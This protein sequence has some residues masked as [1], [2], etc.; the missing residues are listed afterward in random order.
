MFERYT[1]KARRVIFFARYEASEYGSTL[2]EGEHL[3]LGILREAGEL[4]SSLSPLC[5][6]TS[7]RDWL[8]QRVLTREKVP[9]S[10]D[11]PFS[12]EAKRA[13]HAAAKEAD[14]LGHRE[15][16]P[17]H[18]LLGLLRHQKS[19]TVE[20]LA[21]VGC[22][23]AGARERIITWRARQGESTT[24]TARVSSKAMPN[25]DF[26]RAVSDAIDEAT[27]LQRLSAG[28]E[29]LLLGLLHNE[30]SVAAKILQAHGLTLAGLRALLS[31]DT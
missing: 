29:H 5:S 9:T 27:S 10:V 11:L 31:R 28:T 14:E 20:A 15:I 8:D 22:E 12:D 30:Q 24:P 7:V 2:I 16:G 19:V 3:L 25:S 18:L 23:L 6:L 13:L 4:G 1:D 21:Q 26:Q 17:E